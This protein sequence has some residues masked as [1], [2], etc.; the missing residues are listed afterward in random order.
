[1]PR[2]CFSFFVDSFNPSYI[3]VALA[4]VARVDAIRLGICPHE[5][6][7]KLADL[8][9][10][11]NGAVST[12]DD[13]DLGYFSFV[14][15]TGEKLQAADNRRDQSPRES[16]YS[17]AGTLPLLK[18]MRMSLSTRYATPSLSLGLSSHLPDAVQV[19]YT[20]PDIVAVLP[21][22]EE[23]KLADGLRLSAIFLALAERIDLDLRAG[24]IVGSFMVGSLFESPF[25]GLLAL[26]TS[27]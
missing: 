1:M 10:E 23:P 16:T 13:V 8:G 4:G 17:P 18:S 9:A 22:P 11:R 19:L 7:C 14:F 24:Q 27:F 20:R 6:V 26:P 25:R 12:D 3:A 15:R 21:H 5:I 2:K